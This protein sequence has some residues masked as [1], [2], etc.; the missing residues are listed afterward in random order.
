M[1]AE[2]HP[3]AFP[4]APATAEVDA[5]SKQRGLLVYRSTTQQQARRPTALFSLWTVNGPFLFSLARE[6]RN[7]GSNLPAMGMAKEKLFFSIPFL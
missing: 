6:K 3:H 1:C 4:T 7:R 5:E 2:V